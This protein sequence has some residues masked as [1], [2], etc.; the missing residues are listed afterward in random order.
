M[1]SNEYHFALKGNDIVCKNGHGGYTV[2]AHVIEKRP[3][4]HL[5]RHAQLAEDVE[6]LMDS[7]L[8]DTSGT[9][10]ADCPEVKE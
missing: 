3:V 1:R 2:I 6:S 5:L 7:F 10:K 4:Q 9:E 8:F